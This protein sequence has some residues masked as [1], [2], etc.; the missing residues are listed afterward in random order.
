MPS[1]TNAP[2]DNNGYLVRTS[3]RTNRPYASSKFSNLTYKESLARHQ[4]R[5]AA[6]IDMGLSGVSNTT[7]SSHGNFYS[8]QLSTDFLEGPQSLREKREWYRHFYKKDEIVG[9]AIDI[10]TELPLSKMR[11]VAPKPRTCPP[12]FKSP[13]NY[14]KYI[15][16]RFEK[17]ADRIKLAQR[18]ST[19]I[20]HYWLDGVCA[21]FAE[22][23]TV[24]IPDDIGYDTQ[25]VKTAVLREDGTAEEVSNQVRV[26]KPSREEEELAYYAK[27]YQGWAKLIVIPI[28]RVKVTSMPFVD[29]V[30]VELIP[31]PEDRAMIDRANNGDPIAEEMIQEIPAEVREYLSSGQLIPMGTDPDEGSFVYL[32]HGRKLADDTLGQSILDR[33][34][35][36]LILRDKLRQAQTSIASRAMTPHRIVWAENLSD[37][38]TDDLREQVDLALQDPDYSIVTNYEVHWEEMTSRDRL[39]DLS[40]EFERTDRLLITGLG[41]TDSLMNGESLY[42]GDRLKLHII[43]QRYFHLREIVQDYVENQL[44]KP[45]ARRMGFVEEDEWGDERVLYPKLSFTRLPL[46]DS[47]DMFDA[48]MGLYQKGSLSVDLILELLNIDPDDTRIKIE[49]DLMTANDATFNEITRSAYSEIGRVLATDTDM[50]ERVARYLK[51]RIKEKPAGEESRF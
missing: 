31:T 41:V 11:L 34:L 2:S 19:M 12:R 49:Q 7:I 37:I 3:V 40:S 33:C 15:L 50:L 9:Q 24:D 21:V 36:T 23:S 5:T 44:F 8:P 6:G 51:L 4:A 16:S 13:E 14:G 17:M 30:K 45:V 1:Y 43:N 32:L 22:D 20:L 38:D 26:E 25:V 28:D 35:G 47:Q 48:L 46:Q 39:L 27:N 18:L 42:S 10:H 29:K